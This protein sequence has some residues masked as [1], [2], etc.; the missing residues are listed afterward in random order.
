MRR[1]LLIVWL[2]GLPLRA[3]AAEPAYL[4]GMLIQP[5]A[6][7]THLTFTL[8]NKTFGRVKTLPNPSR[9]IIEFEHT[10]K[11]FTL[12]HATFPISFIKSMSMHSTSHGALQI[13]F[14]VNGHVHART[15][16]LPDEKNSGARL[17][18]DLLPALPLVPA[19]QHK[20]KPPVIRER[21]MASVTPLLTSKKSR[22]FTVVIDAGHG[23]HDPGATGVRGTQEKQVVLS[24]AKKLAQEI[25]QQPHMRAVMT[26]DHD[27]FV[28]LA[29]RL[30]LARKG[31]ADL[32]VA[33]HA[34]AYFNNSAS[35]ASVY[36]LSQRG[37]SSVAARWLAQKEN[38][39]ELD[40]VE[41]NALK[42]QSPMLRSVL[43]DL[44]QTSTS[45]DSIRLGINVLDAL[46]S[47][48][49][50]HYSHVERA[51]FLVLKSPDIPSILVETGFLSN[52]REEQRLADPHYQ[53]K[54]AHALRVGIVQYVKKYGMLSVA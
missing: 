30:K 22:L 29:Q 13:V 38:H 21:E 1:L 48:T 43:I 17:Q 53:N 47:I 32:F 52:P 41:L 54:V 37:A 27:Y 6:H 35:G 50:L 42:D 31:E 28:P 44:A 19:T 36:V 23:G 2:I 18:L 51:P 9:V 10:Q 46:E 4:T 11:H 34:D 39:S 8:T 7:A 20:L 5:S 12:E 14:V 24:I 40:G 33:I 45:Q 15:H 49:S 26:R 16:F 3:I 25:N